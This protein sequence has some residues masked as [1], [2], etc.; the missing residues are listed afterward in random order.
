MRKAQM[1]TE[2]ETATAKS[3]VTERGHVAHDYPFGRAVELNF[4]PEYAR[5]R[6]EEPLTRIHMPYGE[7]GWLVTR[8]DDVRKVLSDARFSHAARVNADLP[9]TT[10]DRVMR[11]DDLMNLDAPKHTR[12]RRLI[13]PHFTPKRA[14]AMRAWVES[15]VD[16]LIDE[17]IAVGSPVDLVP[18][19]TEAVPVAVVCR[20]LGAPLSDRPVFVEGA[21]AFVSNENVTAEVRLAALAKLYD[22]IGGLVAVR[23]A[24]PDGPGDDVL[25]DLI[26]ARD[27]EGDRLSEQ[28]LVGL[29]RSFFTAGH[30]TSKNTTGNVVI[31]LQQERSRWNRLVEHP[32]EIPAVLEE[33]LRWIPINPYAQNPRVAVADVEMFG[34]VVR[35]GEA[36][37]PST[38]GG[39][40]D[41]EAYENP[42]EIDLDRNL[43]TGHLFFGTGPHV[44]P[45]R[46]VARVEIQ[47]MIRGL[48]SRLPSLEIDSIE[49]S[50]TGLVR[51]PSSLVVRW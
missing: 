12:V 50:T 2:T 31:V 35:A 11:A 3:E 7:D 13:A 36:V 42:D 21:T 14:E 49:W 22:Y 41:P 29:C 5:I 15:V 25:G 28:E 6:V 1:A 19:L 43:R 47:S 45:G 16:D 8:Y 20:M 38:A 17:M 26:A 10:P 44:C 46:Y 9:R 27:A 4:N 32:D 23:R 48:V 33:L 30:E 39:N 18:A 51:G 37:I 40:R 34:G 24:N